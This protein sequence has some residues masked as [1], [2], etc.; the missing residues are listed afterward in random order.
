MDFSSSLLA[1]NCSFMALNEMLM[2]LMMPAVCW[3]MGA[4]KMDELQQGCLGNLR[5]GPTVLP[6]WL[7]LGEELTMLQ[8][9]S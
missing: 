8:I 4:S 9:K 7:I 1:P 6:V 5:T 3:S 2:K